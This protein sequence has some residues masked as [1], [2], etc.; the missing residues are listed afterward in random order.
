MPF[1]TTALINHSSSA[2]AADLL[3]NAREFIKDKLYFTS[4]SQAP[5]QYPNVHFFTIDHLLVYVNFYSDFG[6]SNLAHV[7]RFCEMMQEKFRLIVQKRTPDEAYQPLV[8]VTPSFLP[9][10]DAG[11]GA[12]T[13]HI[14]IHDCLKGLDKA[15]HLGLVDLENIDPDEYEF[16]EKVENGDLNWLTDKFIAM[17]SP[18]EDPPGVVMSN[19][20]QLLASQSKFTMLSSQG[21]TT[22]TTTTTTTAM[23]GASMLSRSNSPS[24]NPTG[25]PPNSTG[26]QMIGS[27]GKRT[28]YPACRIDD[29][30]RLLKEKGVTTVVRLNNKIYDRK[31]FV[32]A[33]LEHVELYFPDGTTP[34]DGILKRFLELC[35]S[36]PGVIAV[37]CKAGLGRTGTLIGAYLMKHYKFTASEVI[38][39]LRVLR[40]GSVVGPQQNYLQSM[41]SKLFK[42]HPSV[43]LPPSI[44]M[45]KEPTFPVSQRFPASDV[46]PSLNLLALT[47]ATTAPS[48]IIPQRKSPYENSTTDPTSYT[49][50]STTHSHVNTKPSL[51]VSTGLSNAQQQQQD[52]QNMNNETGMDM[53]DSPM[54]DNMSDV[55]DSVMMD[56]VQASSPT[57]MQTASSSQ[58]GQQG[59]AKGTAAGVSGTYYYD[60]VAAATAAMNAA[61]MDYEAPGRGQEGYSI[62]IQ[63]RKQVTPTSGTSMS[64]VSATSTRKEVSSQVVRDYPR[65][66]IDSSAYTWKRTSSAYSTTTTTKNYITVSTTPSANPNPNLHSQTQTTQTTQTRYNLRSSNISQAPQYAY[67][68]SSSSSSQQQQQQPRSS[69][70]P[71]SA[72]GAFSSPTYTSTGRS[73]IYQQQQQQQSGQGQQQQY[74]TSRGATPTMKDE[75]M[76]IASGGISMPSGNIERA[77]SRL[78]SSSGNSGSGFSIGPSGTGM[79]MSGFVLT[80]TS[81]NLHGHA[82]GDNGDANNG[83]FGSSGSSRKVASTTSSGSSGGSGREYGQ[84][85]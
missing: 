43:I 19:H 80:G 25:A 46:H 29:L 4:L 21:G 9:Y 8:G 23:M 22:T 12:A 47:T 37:H 56:T 41:Q 74:T 83:G 48:S 69:S 62:P 54:D 84:R 42:L 66:S 45:L 3:S 63:P 40:P 53:G 57:R 85:K 33:G 36:R 52:L 79:G 73:N 49:Y 59:N 67:N 13:Y 30:I 10:R 14:T 50:R 34:P 61:T 44:S 72:A 11:Y 76:M 82:G 18:K 17:A 15:L 51:T 28:Y 6:P 71:S 1:A 32:D 38:G 81:K 68:T 5:Q 77:S 58:G 60:A 39:L 70:R 65:P 27:G 2:T 7:I 24:Y 75:S 26:I 64:G 55:V 20:Q 35:E 31:K 16:Y 78:G